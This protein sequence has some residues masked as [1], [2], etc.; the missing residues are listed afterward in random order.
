MPIQ[1]AKDKTTIRPGVIYVAPPNYHLLV[2]DD[3]TLALSIDPR[4]NFSRPAIDVLFES[5]VDVYAHHI[6]GVIL[7]GGNHDGA[8]GLRRIKEAGGL[9]IVQDPKTAKAGMM[10]AAALAATAVDYVLPLPE[11]GA[12]LARCGT[13]V[14]ARHHDDSSQRCGT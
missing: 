13:R 11:I 12:L 4:V 5:A 6:I 3:R 14:K 1:E 9:T 2:E 8:H 7:T 10:P